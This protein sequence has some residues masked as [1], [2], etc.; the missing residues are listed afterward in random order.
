MCV[1]VQPL[2]PYR[3]HCPM[4]QAQQGDLL[5]GVLNSASA[6]CLDGINLLLVAMPCCKQGTCV[7]TLCQCACR[8]CAVHANRPI[9]VAVLYCASLDILCTSC[10]CQL[11]PSGV[12]KRRCQWISFDTSAT[13]CAVIQ[14]CPI[15]HKEVT[16]T[17]AVQAIVPVKP[18]SAHRLHKKA[19]SKA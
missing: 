7:H 3:L 19:V 15:C 9:L 17:G 4:A 1:G 11:G 6:S 8:D 5:L 10:A 16:P 14:V 12:S 2:L 13:H 18:S